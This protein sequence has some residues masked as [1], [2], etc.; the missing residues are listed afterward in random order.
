MGGLAR[1]ARTSEAQIGASDRQSMEVV[2][3]EAWT[4]ATGHWFRWRRSGSLAEPGSSTA[5]PPGNPRGPFWAAHRTER[6]EGSVGQALAVAGSLELPTDGAGD[7]VPPD[8]S[9]QAQIPV[10]AAVV[11]RRSPWTGKMCRDKVKHGRAGEI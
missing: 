9:G 1:H 10:Y 2:L 6:R 5:P 11:P 3:V 8:E 4:T 7:P